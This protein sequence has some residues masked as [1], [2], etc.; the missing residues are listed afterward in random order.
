MMYTNPP[1]KDT[2]TPT[3]DAEAESGEPAA[4]DD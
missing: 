2:E 1:T 4:A 3:A